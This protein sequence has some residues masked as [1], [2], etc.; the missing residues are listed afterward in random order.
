MQIAGVERTVEKI[1]DSGGKCT[2]YHCD[3][4][5]R[6]EVYKSAKA[7]KV[8]VGNVSSSLILFDKTLPNVLFIR[9][10]INSTKRQLT[11]H[12]W[13]SFIHNSLV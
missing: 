13:F 6:D 3:I 10:T 12:L 9:Q 1:R 11:Q 8:D 4:A 7:V 5:N 2:G